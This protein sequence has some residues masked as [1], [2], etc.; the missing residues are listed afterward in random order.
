MSFKSFSRVRSPDGLPLLL[1]LAGDHM[2]SSSSSSSDSS[3]TSPPPSGIP[4]QTSTHP[5]NTQ[6]AEGAAEE[7]LAQLLGSLLGGTAVGGGREAGSGPAPSINVTL[8]GGPGIFQGLT[9]FSQVSLGVGK[10]SWRRE[11]SPL[12][13]DHVHS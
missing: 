5:S 13:V 9:D 12:W 1:T 10:S 3:S 8:P 7:N 2:T 6:P 11:E 4:T